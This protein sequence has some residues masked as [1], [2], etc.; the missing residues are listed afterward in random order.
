MGDQLQA[1]MDV[2]Q[3]NSVLFIFRMFC[4]RFAASTATP[5]A[6]YISAGVR[7]GRSAHM[8]KLFLSSLAQGRSHADE[9][10]PPAPVF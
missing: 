6:S 8:C 1:E 4:N 5:K 2:P 3:A 9:L 7:K 10:Q